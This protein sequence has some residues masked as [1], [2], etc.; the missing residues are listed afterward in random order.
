MGCETEL[1][2]LAGRLNGLNIA[3]LMKN[4]LKDMDIVS[5][6]LVK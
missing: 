6:E 5:A 1:G 3:N 4:N 2:E